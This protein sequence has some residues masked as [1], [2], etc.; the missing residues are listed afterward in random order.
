[1]DR[2]PPARRDHDLDAGALPLARILAVHPVPA[3]RAHPAAG[4]AARALL[5][6]GVP[7]LRHALHPHGRDHHHRARHRPGGAADH[8][9]G[10][11]GVALARRRLLAHRGRHRDPRGAR[12]GARA[13]RQRAV[14]AE[15]AAARA[16]APLA[17]PPVR[18]WPRLPRPPRRSSCRGRRTSTP[19][20]RCR[21]FP[22]ARPTGTPTT[23]AI[24]RRARTSSRR[25]SPRRT[26]SRRRS[27]PGAGRRLRQPLRRQPGTRGTRRRRRC[28]RARSGGCAAAPRHVRWHMLDGASCAFGEIATRRR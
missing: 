14:R 11:R 5:P 20:L 25:S 15:E 7:A 21:C 13:A 18:P 27:G 23:P 9:A 12:H 6:Q 4:A 16:H 19:S 3:D 1:M 24:R 10:V 26:S 22:T 28:R 8:P 17:A 2:R